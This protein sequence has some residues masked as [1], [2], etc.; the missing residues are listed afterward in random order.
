MT[1]EDVYH[2]KVQAISNLT[3]VYTKN[4]YAKCAVASH[5]PANTKRAAEPT[6]PAQSSASSIGEIF[7]A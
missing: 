5:A 6:Q 7:L 1:V 2:N 4:C 3:E